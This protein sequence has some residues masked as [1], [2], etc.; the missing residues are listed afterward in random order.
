MKY[1]SSVRLALIILALV[2]ASCG[3]DSAGTN[4]T[5]PPEPLDLTAR[6]AGFELGSIKAEYFEAISYGPYDENLF[7]IYVPASDEPA[8]RCG[9]ASTMTWP[10]RATKTLSCARRRV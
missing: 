8:P 10:T 3:G 7:D 4:N 5:P 9:L 6:A 2:V 1:L